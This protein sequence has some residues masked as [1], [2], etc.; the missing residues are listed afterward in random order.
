MFPIAYADRLHYASMREMFDEEE[1]SYVVSEVVDKECITTGLFCKLV[2]PCGAAN[3]ALI[4]VK[5][6]SET[7]KYEYSAH[8]SL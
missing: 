3:T 1:D 8:T 7:C 2:M 6:Y 5:H 4:D